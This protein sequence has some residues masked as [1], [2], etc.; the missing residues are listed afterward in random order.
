MQKT[1]FYKRKR[2]VKLWQYMS[3]AKLLADCLIYLEYKI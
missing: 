3:S 1:F 2:A